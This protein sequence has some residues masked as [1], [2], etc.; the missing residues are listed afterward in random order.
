MKTDRSS[1]TMQDNEMYEIH[2]EGLK[3]RQVI[4]INKNL[5]I[6]NN[7]SQLTIRHNDRLLHLIR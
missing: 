7:N 5:T 3:N 4:C 1:E 2:V 6:N